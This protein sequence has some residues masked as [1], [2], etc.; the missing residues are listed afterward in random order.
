[1][2]L[3]GAA[4]GDP[5]FPL[6]TYVYIYVCIDSILFYGP[7]TWEDPSLTDPHTHKRGDDD[8]LDVCELGSDVA[9]TGQ[10]KQVKVLGALAILDQGETDWKI[11]AIDVHDPLASKIDCVADV[12]RHMPTYLDVMKY[13]FRVYKVPDGKKENEIA[14]GAEV[15]DRK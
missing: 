5:P 13:W 12:E 8:P 9:S 10:V 11:I 3:R 14:M 2:E 15:M 4:A 7:Q 1:M 6:T